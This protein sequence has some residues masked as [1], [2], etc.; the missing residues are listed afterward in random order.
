M[1]KFSQ[2]TLQRRLQELAILNR[3]IKI[4]F[5]DKRSGDEFEFEYERGIEEFVER[6]DIGRSLDHRCPQDV[7]EHRAVA[8]AERMRT[9]QGL[10]CLGC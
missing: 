3:G 4:V 8:Q 1:T 7:F 5:T 10:E 6:F 9:L 2:S